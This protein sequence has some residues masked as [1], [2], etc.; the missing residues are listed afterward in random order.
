M[1]IVLNNSFLSIVKKRNSETELLVRARV[2][3]D[4][5]NVFPEAEVFEDTS[6]DYRYRSYINRDIVAKAISDHI[7]LIDYDNFKNSVSKNDKKRS[8]AYMNVWAALY[9]LQT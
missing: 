4:I 6:A 2:K 3:T 5:H 7:S 1:W 8:A 9:Q